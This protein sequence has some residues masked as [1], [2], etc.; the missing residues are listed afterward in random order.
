MKSIIVAGVET[1]IDITYRAQQA[2]ESL[3]CTSDAILE[4]HAQGISG[5][6]EDCIDNQKA[7][8]DGGMIMTSHRLN[9][10]VVLFIVTTAS[11]QR[12]VIYS[13]SDPSSF[14]HQLE[15]E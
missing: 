12:T 6:A 5:C 10:M 13:P 2:L 1:P 15:T 7:F 3:G 9:G 4:R 11:R 8:R 14:R